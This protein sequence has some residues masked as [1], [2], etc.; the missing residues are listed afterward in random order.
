MHKLSFALLGDN[1]AGLVFGVL[2]EQ[3]VLA[4]API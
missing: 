2:A 3:R 1:M 4:F